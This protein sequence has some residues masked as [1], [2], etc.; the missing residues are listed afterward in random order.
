MK[1]VSD[2]FGV[3]FNVGE[4]SASLALIGE[5]EGGQ[6]DATI[7]AEINGSPSLVR[8]DASLV[9]QWLAT[10]DKSNEVEIG[11]TSGSLMSFNHSVTL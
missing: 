7:K 6:S 4:D 5:G 3:T 10:I 1:V 11:S 8:L 9:L 2:L